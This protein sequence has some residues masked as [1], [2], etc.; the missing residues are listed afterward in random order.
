MSDGR[1]RRLLRLLRGR[2][3]AVEI[4]SVAASLVAEQADAS[5]EDVSGE[6]VQTVSRD[7]VHV[8][9][10][11]LEGAELVRWDRDAGT[12]EATDHPAFSHPV[13]G[14]ILNPAAV[15]DVL[16]VPE[17]AVDDLLD[18][19]S[20]P[21]CR[22]ILSVL[23]AC[24][25]TVDRDDLA[26][27]LA[28]SESGA[29]ESRSL[30]LDASPAGRADGTDDST[31]AADLRMA[32]HHVHLPHLEDAGLVEYDPEDGTVTVANE[33]VLDERLLNALPTAAANGP[34]ARAPLGNDAGQDG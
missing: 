29:G 23:A 33:A 21:P 32:L 15:P 28:D 8:D 27:E 18:V 5:P 3:G 24:D 7:L 4:R 22:R 13:V 9:L 30:S 26:E 6:E 34:E 12:V 17:A 10:P 1:R 19:L 16:D 20:R 25:G 31:D 11:R 14:A 2:S